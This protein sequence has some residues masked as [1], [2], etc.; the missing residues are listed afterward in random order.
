MT[1][2]VES[3]HNIKIKD[4]TVIVSTI[5]KILIAILLLFAIYIHIFGNNFP[6]GGFQSAIILSSAYLLYYFTIDKKKFIFSQASLLNI[7]IIGLLIYLITG[8]IPMLLGKKF[9]D[10]MGFKEIFHFNKII[11]A[12]QLMVEFVEFAIMLVIF[13]SIVRIILNLLGNLKQKEDWT[14]H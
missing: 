10:K 2:N 14:S 13:S 9:F 11:Q 1:D 6:G 5:S 12:N 4:D 3:I 7:S 8:F